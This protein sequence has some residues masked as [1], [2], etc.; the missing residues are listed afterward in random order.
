MTLGLH[1]LQ[2][3]PGSRRKRHRVGRGNASGSGTY[4]GRGQKG[5]RA[6]SGGRSGLKRRGLRR[7][8]QSK[9][10]IGGF[11]SLR[12]KLQVVDLQHLE[13]RFDA[14]SIVTPK[15]LLDLGLI[16]SLT[17]GV[18]VLGNG[19]LTKKMTVVAHAFSSSAPTAITQ[20]GGTL[21]QL[22]LHKKPVR[23]SK[24]TR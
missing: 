11:K 10:K 4:S 14:G 5:Q 1:N 15:R 12:P 9:P 19:K 3:K 16:P 24:K 18:K 7:M 17:P 6:R 23:P 22:R 21:Q 2:P 13:D 20:A 8:L